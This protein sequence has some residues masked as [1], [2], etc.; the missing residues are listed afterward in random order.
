MSCK[1]ENAAAAEARGIPEI[2]LLASGVDREN[3]SALASA[4]AAPITV[5]VRGAAVAKGRAR[6]TRT[7]FAYTPAKTRQYEAHGRLAAQLAMGEQPPLTGPVHLTALIELPI[8]ASWSK[9]R[10]AAAIVGEIRPTSRPDIDNFLKSGM[11]AINGIV[12]A[13]DSLVVEV[14]AKKKF[15]VDP[16]LVLLI[17]PINAMASNREAS[18]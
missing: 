16:K 2:D 6:F 18:R 1:N 12:L 5:T 9:R 14:T 10:T 17:T 13:D 4:Q 8:P 11:D 15:G 3:N 7:G